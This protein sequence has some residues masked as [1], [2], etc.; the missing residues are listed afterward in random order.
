MPDRHVQ[1]PIL[2]IAVGFYLLS[3]PLWVAVFL[4][5]DASGKW[6]NAVAA[7]LMVGLGLLLHRRRP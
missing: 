5:Q 4:A 6:T 2:P 7:S 3:L 1:N